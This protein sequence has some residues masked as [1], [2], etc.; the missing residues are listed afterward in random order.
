MSRI[1]SRAAFDII[2]YANSWED[3]DVLC[4]ALQPAPGKR[5]LA[6]ASAG[7][8][9]FALLAGG[10]E[11]V[12]ADLSA[13]QLALVDLK[14]AAIR[15]L[16]DEDVLRFLGVKPSS[17]RLRVY[18][19]LDV[20]PETRALLK[21]ED[22]ARGV[23]HAGR[24]ENYFRLFRKWVLPLVHSRRDVE[25]LLSPHAADF[26]AREWNTWRWRAMFRLF[27]SRFVM[28][29][30]GRDPEFFRYVEGSVAERIFK[31]AEYALTEL[32][33]HTNPYL[34]LI[35]T[36]NYR[37]ILP[38]Y[39]RDLAAVRRN[40]E[41]LTLVRGSIDEAATGTFDGFYLSDIFE[42]VDPATHAAMYARLLGAANPGARLAYWNLLVP[43]RV[44]PQFAPRVRELREKA[45]AL[46]AQDQA[47]FYSAFVLEEVR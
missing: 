31:R 41:K 6:I 42:Y 16:E 40:L 3:A 7:D 20:P 26:Y 28:G 8:N 30:T 14:R 19:G 15:E 44:P 11:V 12:A 4:E 33:P 2:R 13:A 9:A 47:F 22:V 1:D 5:M 18:R 17:D 46:F 21:D 45:D 34:A 27:F 38:R 39:L 10:A 37:D 25:R 23:I 43:R 35:F 32:T 29:R 24:F 36:G